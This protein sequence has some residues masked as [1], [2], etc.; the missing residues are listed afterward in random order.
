L[1]RWLGYSL[2]VEQTFHNKIFICATKL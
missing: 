1:M 2:F